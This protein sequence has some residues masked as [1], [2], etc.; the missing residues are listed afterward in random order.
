MECRTHQKRIEIIKNYYVKPI[1]HNIIINGGYIKGDAG[2]SLKNEYYKF[3]I[4]NKSNINE[5][6]TIICG[7]TVAYDFA[8]ILNIKLPPIFNIFIDDDY[9]MEDSKTNNNNNNKTI[10][11]STNKQL[12]NA[13]RIIMLKYDIKPFSP[14]YSIYNDVIKNKNYINY[15]NIK[16]CNTILLK[17]NKNNPKTLTDILNEFIIKNSNKQIKNFKFNELTNY[18]IKYTNYD[19]I[20]LK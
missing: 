9:E 12:Y 1:E 18:L 17:L 15:N 8:K 13:I 14:L 2:K 20:Y 3:I 5:I 4:K 10:W 11:N 19:K 16:G 7:N 6:D